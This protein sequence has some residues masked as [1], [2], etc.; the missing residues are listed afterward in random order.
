MVLVTHGG[1]ISQTRDAYSSNDDRVGD[2]SAQ[3]PPLGLPLVPF[4]KS[5]KSAPKPHL[6]YQLRSIVI[7][8]MQPAKPIRWFSGT[9]FVELSGKYYY[10]FIR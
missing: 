8:T 10:M 6:N 1:K 2:K 7:F 5:T 9:V 4:P 3:S